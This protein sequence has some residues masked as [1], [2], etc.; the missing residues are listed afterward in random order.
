[1]MV[2]TSSYLLKSRSR[3]PA[4]IVDTALRKLEQSNLDGGAAGLAFKIFICF[5]SS[6]LAG[7]DFKKMER[8]STC[9]NPS[10]EIGAS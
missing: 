8:S 2:L 4:A 9:F 6:S 7:F 5:N 3:K 1:M 10:V